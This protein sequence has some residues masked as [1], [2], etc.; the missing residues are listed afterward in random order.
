[1]RAE[2]A[3]NLAA[4]ERNCA[5]LA[6]VG[7]RLCAVVKADAYGHGAVPSARAALAGGATW[8]ATATAAEAIGLRRAEID[9]PILVM[10][11]LTRAE[12]EHAV[13]AGADVVAWT[14]Q[15][16][17]WVSA[18]GGGRVHVKLDTG[19]GRLGTRD[20][21]LADRLIDRADAAGGVELVGAM[22]HF[23]T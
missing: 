9:A 3:V 16:I 12:A 15:L 11:A 22:T 5:V 18:A 10:G 20:T 13:E 19:M 17:D 21:E 14:E 7:P 4:I 6:G 8:L 2:A 1:M 23:A